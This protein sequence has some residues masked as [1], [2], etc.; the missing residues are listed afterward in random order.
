MVDLS[1]SVHLLTNCTDSPGTIL[2]NL[3][4]PKVTGFLRTASD[5]IILQLE[6]LS[7]Y[8]LVQ[9]KPQS[10]SPPEKIAGD[11]LVK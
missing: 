9:H 3:N 8:D 6:Y 11:N 2:S 4:A 5:S 10:P 1:S 7:Q